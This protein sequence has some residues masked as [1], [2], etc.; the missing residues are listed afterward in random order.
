MEPTVPNRFVPALVSLAL[1]FKLGPERLFSRANIDLSAARAPG[2]RF[3][4]REVERLVDAFVA[5]TK[6]PQL[7]LLLGEHL[8]PES[9]GLF[10]QLVTT[11]ATPREALAT[12]S[13]FKLLLHPAFDLRCEEQ[14]DD[15]IVRYASNDGSPI[16]DRPYYAEALLAAVVTLSSHFLGRALKTRAATFRHA[17]PAYAD[18]YRRVFGCEIAW[19][20]PSDSVTFPAG[21]LDA[22]LLSHSAA[23]HRTLRAQAQT[24]LSRSSAL[25]PAQVRRVIHSRVAEPELSLEDVAKT[26]ALSARTLQRRLRDAGVGFRELRDYVRHERAREL[27]AGSDLTVD[28]VA[29][30]LGYTDRSN[31]VRA[32]ARWQGQ[33]PSAFRAGQRHAAAGRR[34]PFG[35]K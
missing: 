17:A 13:D 10:G 6:L 9:I 32:F 8:D 2:A 21:F 30:A 11:S 4:V 18:E 34:S 15:V 12:F 5:E 35:A 33:S 29:S 27:L 26:L 14:G 23:Y 25:A 31:F 7:A 20:S 3:S 28:A 19:N 24:E 16:G 1:R 22:P